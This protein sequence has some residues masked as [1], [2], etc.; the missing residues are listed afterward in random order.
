MYVAKFMKKNHNKI[1]TNKR[2]VHLHRT[3]DI[4]E[5][6]E[7]L[8][9]QGN[10][11]PM[12]KFI[13]SLFCCSAALLFADGDSEILIPEE[14]PTQAIDVAKLSEAFGH[15][16]GK[17]LESMG[18]KFDIAKVMQGF[19]DSY[20]GKEAPMTE[21]ECAQSMAAIHEIAFKETASENL[22]KAEEFLAT[23]E[24]VEGIISLEDGK[25]QYLINQEGTG[26]TVE[27]TSTPLIQYTGKFLDGAVFGASTEE[28]LVNL[29]ETIPGFSKGL[30]GMK[31]G[32]KRT[33]F[34]HPDLGYGTH[35]PPNS[36]LM[37]E[38]EVVQANAPH[39]QNNDAPTSGNPEIAAPFEEPAAIR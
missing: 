3:I 28:E 15:L 10:G 18:M 6:A 31:E 38:V 23:N 7:Y 13:L 8:R 37:F 5:T 4:K 36:L 26:D 30:L 35:E 16:L 11:V 39:A 33:L 29:D 1:L 9:G 21:I 24:H 19:K 22:K 12:K 27:E 34:I 2:S 25:L 17:N 14:T 32:E 20:E